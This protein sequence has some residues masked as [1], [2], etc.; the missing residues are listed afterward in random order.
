MHVKINQLSDGPSFALRIGE[1][2]YSSRPLTLEF[3]EN[4]ECYY[5]RMILASAI[6]HPSWWTITGFRS[7]SRISG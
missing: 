4:T 6:L 7:I 3:A 1:G 2:F 5:F